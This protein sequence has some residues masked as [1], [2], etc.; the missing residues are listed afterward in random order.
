MIRVVTA[1]LGVLMLLGLLESIE[2][3]D[4]FLLGVAGEKETLSVGFAYLEG[5]RLM[6]LHLAQLCKQQL[7][8]AILDLD[9]FN[10]FVCT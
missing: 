7:T 3:A 6:A 9:F 4:Q 5:V 2:P 1:H 10:S 8:V